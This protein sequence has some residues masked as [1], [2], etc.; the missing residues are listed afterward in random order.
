MATKFLYL[1]HETFAPAWVDGGRVPIFSARKY[2]SAEREGINTPDESTNQLAIGVS[3]DDVE[4]VRSTIV[5]ASGGDFINRMILPGNEIRDGVSIRFEEWN[6][7]IL[8]LS[9]FESREICGR[10]GKSTCVAIDDHRSLIRDISRQLGLVGV[11]RSCKYT[12]SASRGIFT[13][14]Y[15]DA[16]QDEYRMHWPSTL[17]T[18]EVTVRAGTARMLWTL[19]Q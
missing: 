7:L 2:L 12:M 16:W 4:T 14:S 13:K 18:I 6:G 19:P 3:G 9:N 1:R 10:L 11:G 17:A 8:C 15:K 5:G